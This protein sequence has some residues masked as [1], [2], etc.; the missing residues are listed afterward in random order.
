MNTNTYRNMYKIIFKIMGNLTPL[1]VD[2]GVLCGGACCKGDENIG[3]KLFPHE[4]S[5]LEIR[6]NSSGERLAICNGTCNRT[7]RPL[8]CRIFPFFPTIDENGKIF[9]ELDY[10]AQRLCP[11]IE[12]SDELLFDP[13]FFKAVKKVGKILSKDEECKAF[14]RD[15]T[16]EIDMFHSFYQK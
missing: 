8:A 16:D 9:V 15:S 6:A 7:E 1:T 11:M 14:L 5:A 13:K 4:D 10:R 2:C 12:H 3:M